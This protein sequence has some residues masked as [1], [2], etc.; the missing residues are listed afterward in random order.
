MET[1]QM[2]NSY[3]KAYA[4]LL[5]KLR[6]VEK[7]FADQEHLHRLIE[8]ISST[9]REMLD[10]WNRAT[11]FVVLEI[12]SGKIPFN[13]VQPESY[14]ILESVWEK[15]IKL[16]K[17]YF[18]WFN[19]KTGDA[20]SNYFKASQEI[21]KLLFIPSDYSLHDF[22]KIKN[23]LNDRYLGKDGKIDETK[24]STHD[25]IACKAERIYHTTGNTN[26]IENWFRAKLYVKFFYENIIP[27]IVNNESDKINYILK[28]FEFSK[29][30][31]NR[32]LIINCFEAAIAIYFINKERLKLII[33]DPESYAFNMVPIHGWPATFSTPSKKFR[34]DSKVSLI[35]YEGVMDKAEQELLKEKSLLDE[36]KVAIDELYRQSHLEPFS[37]MIL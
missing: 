2:L 8:S 17:A 27:A 10:D 16:L 28:A 35:T 31:N 18:V 4:Y 5:S 1:K 12:L 15:D 37:D 33:N 24:Q 14:P 34:F 25:L 36:H 7:V 30:P 23:Y 20:D 11:S 19:N 26:S 6:K 9:E 13:Q 29:S 32:F 21:R 3:V 22:D